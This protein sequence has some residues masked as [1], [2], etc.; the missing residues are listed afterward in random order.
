V[1]DRRKL[2]LVLTAVTGTMAVLIHFQLFPPAVF[3][4]L[5]T[6]WLHFFAVVAVCLFTGFML[7]L[8]PNTPRRDLVRRLRLACIVPFGFLALHELGQWLWPAGE[9]DH[10]DSVRDTAM[11]ALGAWLAWRVLRS[12]LPPATTRVAG[13]HGN[14][15][16]RAPREEEPHRF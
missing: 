13:V 14:R 15:T 2:V 8:Q 3:V 10:F 12:G 7:G 1:T 9:R 11:N 4:H 6:W 5:R 16:H